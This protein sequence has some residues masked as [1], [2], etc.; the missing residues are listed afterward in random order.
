VVIGLL[1][2]EPNDT[3]LTNKELEVALPVVETNSQLVESTEVE[4]PSTNETSQIADEFRELS[5]DELRTM[6]L[7]D[8][9]FYLSDFR[10]VHQGDAD[11]EALEE[12][13][14]MAVFEFNPEVVFSYVSEYY[15]L[16]DDAQLAPPA[17]ISTLIYDT[18]EEELKLA[19]NRYI[20]A[21]Q[22]LPVFWLV[23]QAMRTEMADFFLTGSIESV[24]AVVSKYSING[25]LDGQVS[26]YVLASALNPPGTI[27]D[28]QLVSAFL[29]TP[30]RTVDEGMDEL[31]FDVIQLR[32]D[33]TYPHLLE[34]LKY[35]PKKLNIYRSLKFLEGIQLEAA[36]DDMMSNFQSLSEQDKVYVSLIA[37]DY[38][39]K[40]ALTFLLDYPEKR[41]E[42][43]VAVNIE[44]VLK[45]KIQKPAGEVESVIDWA[46][47]HLNEFRYDSELKKFV[48]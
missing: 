18:P 16:M 13:L 37:L 4:T 14:L 23:T 41:F 32:D 39:Y 2:P 12:A 20:D 1:K 7:S 5:L 48:I 30:P 36:V 8:L 21:Y 11:F 35:Q 26:Q 28:E 46:K 31:I 24:P 40:S 10:W 3:E 17:L 33:R 43:P 15:V 45:Q 19:F 42:G 27:S 29:N 38:G 44:F 25:F 34:C 47:Q 6:S 9:E 22:T